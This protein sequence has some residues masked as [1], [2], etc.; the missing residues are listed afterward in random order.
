[1]PDRILDRRDKIGFATPEREWI[2]EMSDTIRDWL[3]PDIG[4]PF[5]DHK[6]LRREF[7]LI[8]AGGKAFNWQVWRWI[9]FCRWHTLKISNM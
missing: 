5:I 7:D 2:V 3:G 4:V 1:V 9:N 8:I 6:A